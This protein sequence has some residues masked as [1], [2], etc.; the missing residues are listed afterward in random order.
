M[1]SVL[2]TSMSLIIFALICFTSIDFIGMNRDISRVSDAQRLVADYVEMYG[3]AD[4]TGK[5]VATSTINQ[6]NSMLSKNNMSC[7]VVKDENGNGVLHETAGARYYQI[8][9]T[10]TIHSRMFH[11]KEN[12]HSNVIVN[13][14]I[15][16]K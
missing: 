7:E 8:Q 16:K 10:Y 4:E 3:V 11:I 2:E 15:T 13:I 6:I 1:K 12:A 5:T 14:P 9:L